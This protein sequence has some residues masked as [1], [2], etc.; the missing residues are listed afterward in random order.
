MPAEGAMVEVNANYPFS[1][2]LKDNA[3]T[4]ADMPL[5]APHFSMVSIFIFKSV[6]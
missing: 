6:C 5:D 2:M 1:G 4:T 3:T